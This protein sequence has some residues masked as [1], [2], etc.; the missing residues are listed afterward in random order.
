MTRGIAE[1]G[2]VA[3]RADAA[4]ALSVAS[5]ELHG[6]GW[7]P[8]TAG[9]VSVRFGPDSVLITGS[10]LGKGRITAADTVLVAVDTGVPVRPNSVRPSAETSI[11]L[12]IYHAFPEAG[13]VVHAHPPYAT[14]LASRTARACGTSVRFTE[15]ELIKGMIGAHHDRLDIPLFANWPEVPRIA[16]DVTDH[17]TRRTADHPPGLLIAHHGATTWGTDLAQ[18]MDRIECLEALCQLVL[19]VDD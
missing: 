2:A 15:L 5:R 1:I 12:A 11:H 8:G 3:P 14:A 19:L 4:A 17:F 13:A 10:G 9:N 7:M 18:A 16:A 6:L